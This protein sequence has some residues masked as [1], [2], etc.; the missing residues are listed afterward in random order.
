MKYF[1]DN[2]YNEYLI[3]LYQKEVKNLTRILISS[4]FLGYRNHFNFVNKNRL[5]NR[6]L[7]VKSA[8]RCLHFNPSFPET[9]QNVHPKGIPS[10]L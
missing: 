1:I 3:F 4:I 9:W 10:K 2:L 8:D 5:T 7:H 6:G